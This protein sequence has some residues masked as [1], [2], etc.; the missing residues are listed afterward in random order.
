VEAKVFDP[1]RDSLKKM[2]SDQQRKMLL[3]LLTERF[4]LST[5]MQMKPLPIYELVVAKGGPKCKLSADQIT[6]NGDIDVDGSRT[7][8]IID[9]KHATMQALAKTLS[10]RVDRTVV[11]K[12][13]LIGNFDLIWE[14]SVAKV[15]VRHDLFL[16]GPVNF[17]G[18]KVRAVVAGELCRDPSLRSG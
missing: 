10:T 12:T 6:P 8:V 11:D 9:G 4:Q 2:T 5:H 17:V 18:R 7:E 16:A 15:G 14:G 13:G 1:D 3:P